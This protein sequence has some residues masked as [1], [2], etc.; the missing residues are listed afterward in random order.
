MFGTITS[1][2]IVVFGVRLNTLD[3]TNV[4]CG[5]LL[6]GA[7]ARRRFP[8]L[9]HLSRISFAVVITPVFAVCVAAG[10]AIASVFMQERAALATVA[11]S[12]TPP[13]LVALG[14]TAMMF[15]ARLCDGGVM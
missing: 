9:V 8:A 13:P 7:N 12:V 15:G 10:A 5:Q 1:T 14:A 3:V 4:L 2:F 11:P 6:S